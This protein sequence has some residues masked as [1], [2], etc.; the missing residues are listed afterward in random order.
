MSEALALTCADVDLTDGVLTVRAGK[1]G[2]TR[3][4]PCTPPRS[5]RCAT[6]PPAASSTP[7]CHPAATPS[8][9]PTTPTMSATARPCTR[10]NGCVCNWGGPRPDAPAP[11]GFTTY[12]TAWWCAA[13]RPGTPTAA[14]STARSSSWP[15]TSVTSKSETCTGTCPRCQS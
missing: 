6:T 7:A 9:A 8:S 4:V 5:H 11:H 1:R 13:S 2:R 12:A 15:P 14:M 10:S 3:L